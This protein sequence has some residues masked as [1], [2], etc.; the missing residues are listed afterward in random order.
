MIGAVI[1][2]GDREVR[3]TTSLRSLIKFYESP[4]P[5]YVDSLRQL[6]DFQSGNRPATFSGP[7][8]LQTDRPTGEHNRHVKP[9]VRPHAVLKV[10]RV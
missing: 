7:T 6:G 1:G 10:P 5:S 4:L 2:W 3:E 9:R 8:K